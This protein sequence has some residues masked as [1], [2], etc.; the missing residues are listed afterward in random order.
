LATTYQPANA[1]TTFGGYRA[2]AE[3]P[4]RWRVT[5]VSN[6]FSD[7]N[8]AIAM[9]LYRGAVIA[10][11]AGFP[12]MQV[13]DFRIVQEVQGGLWPRGLQTTT[14]RVVGVAD[15][16]APFQCE[17]P[18]RFQSNCRTLGVEET[19]TRYAPTLEQSPAQT[20]AEVEAVRRSPPQPD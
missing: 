14:L 6:S 1:F 4:N 3:A 11:A 7:E 8:F 19:L 18:A 2:K 16:S 5:A 15:P 9:T 12:Y 10:K 20:A 17:A 13:V